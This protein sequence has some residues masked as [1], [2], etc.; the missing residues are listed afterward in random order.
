MDASQPMA[1]M[2]LIPIPAAARAEAFFCPPKHFRV[3]ALFRLMAARANLLTAAAAVVGASQFITPRTSSSGP[4]LRMA[5]LA[6]YM[7]A[8]GRFILSRAAIPMAR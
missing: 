2:A 4:Y 3:P 5:A 1:P 6:R 7:V 8:Q